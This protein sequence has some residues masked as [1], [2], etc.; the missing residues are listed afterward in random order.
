MHNQAQRCEH[1][2]RDERCEP[3]WEGEYMFFMIFLVVHCNHHL[4]Q[5]HINGFVVTIFVEI[6]ELLIG[7]RGIEGGRG[8]IREDVAQMDSII[9]GD[10]VGDTGQ[11]CVWVP[12]SVD[13]FTTYVSVNGC[14]I[15]IEMQ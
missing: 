10:E 5:S 11:D 15:T 4:G 2:V 7:A 1:E 3:C 9:K 8:V 12:V 6:L 13:V 14:K